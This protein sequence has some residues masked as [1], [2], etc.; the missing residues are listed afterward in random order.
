MNALL[1]PEITVKGLLDRYPHLLQL[2]MDL[3]FLCAGCPAEAF[4]SLNDVAKEYR[5]DLNKLIQHFQR[6]IDATDASDLP[7]P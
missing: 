4:H 1:S 5:Y 3:G 7:K 6:I 2:F